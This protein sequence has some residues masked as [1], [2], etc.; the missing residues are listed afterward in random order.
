MPFVRPAAP[1]GRPARA[2]CDPTRR[3]SIA[4]SASGRHYAIEAEVHDQ[5]AVVVHVV[6]DDSENGCPALGLLAAPPRH[7]FQGFFFCEPLPH[8]AAV[9]VA[10]PERLHDL[11]SA[12][13]GVEAGV[14]AEVL[15]GDPTEE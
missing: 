9:V 13:E 5:V 11:R 1:R 4:R 15:A 14:T 6:L 8:P 12:L 3:S 2:Q 7:H 10:F